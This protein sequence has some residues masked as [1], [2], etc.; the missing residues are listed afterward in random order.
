MQATQVSPRQLAEAIGDLWRRTT[1]GGDNASFA[2]IDE[3]GLS[4][5]Q[6]KTLFTLHHCAESVSVGEVSERLGLSLA[7]ASRT[8]DGLLQQGWVQ[9]REDERD[10]RMKRVSITPAGRDVAQRIADARMLGLESFAASLTARAAR[11]PARR[12]RRPSRTPHPRGL[13]A[14]W[15]TASASPRT[16]AAGG[17]S[18]PCASRCSW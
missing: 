4:I 7:A 2:L 10:R 16:T 15:S 13:N 18:P 6:V 17:P 8:I 5:T 3:L 9:R 14:P 12:A 11:P 1:T